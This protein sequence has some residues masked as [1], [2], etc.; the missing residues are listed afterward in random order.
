MI[1][2]AAAEAWYDLVETASNRPSTAYVPFVECALND[3][4][5]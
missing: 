4:R 2:G 3:L 5:R 1:R